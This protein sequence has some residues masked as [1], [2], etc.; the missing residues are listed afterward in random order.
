MEQ[1]PQQQ[2][3]ARRPACGEPDGKRALTR[4]ADS[5]VHGVAA[6]EEELDDPGP[7]EASGAGDAHEDGHGQTP[8][9]VARAAGW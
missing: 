9:S 5:G 8:I 1:Q 3:A 4:V 2:G 7:D 6:G